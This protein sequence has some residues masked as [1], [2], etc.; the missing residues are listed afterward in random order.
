MEVVK[1]NVKRVVGNLQVCAGQQA[2]CEAAIHA[3]RS[4]FD[5]PDCEAVLMVDASNAF[6]CLN[7]EAALHNIKMRCPSLA[8]Y[9][10]NSY[11]VP[12]KLFICGEV[13]GKT[14]RVET[15]LSAEGTTQGDPVAM[16]MYALGLLKLQD[17]LRHEKT[18]VK[19]VAYADDLTGV[20]KTADL[21]KWWE[22]VVQHGPKL[23]YFPNARKSVLIV[24]P[25]KLE[26][27]EELFSGSEI[28]I[29]TEGERHLGAV[30]GSA[31]FREEYVKTKVNDWKQEISSC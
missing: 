6:N 13:T 20:G 14:R 19:Q 4:M 31:I 16:A 10:E 15:I 24:K 18:G 5:H 3:V 12:A 26:Q 27:A 23:G 28:R 7:R 21:I 29:T 8:T 25:E 30:I 17:T 11:K 9:V 22:M 2:G 1:K